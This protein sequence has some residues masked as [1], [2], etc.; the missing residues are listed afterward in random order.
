VKSRGFLKIAKGLLLGSAVSTI[1]L[2]HEVSDAAA[3]ATPNFPLPAITVDR[4]PVT[5]PARVRRRPEQV[6][7][8]PVQNPPAQDAQRSEDPRGPG[9]GIVA[10]QT[11]TGTKTNTSRMEIPQSIS[12]VTR[13]QMDL[14]KPRTL[15]EAT[16]YTLGIREN[17]GGNDTRTDLF[18]IRGFIAEATGLYLN[19]LQLPSPGLAIFRLEPFGLDRIEVLRGPSSVLYGGTNPGGL[20]NAISKRPVF[21]PFGHLEFG[22]NNYGNRYGAF[23]VGGSGTPGADGR[24]TVAYRLTGLGKAGGTQ[25]DYIQDDRWF[26]AP[27][28]TFKPNEDTKLTVL[29]QYQKDQSNNINFLPY[30]GTV[31]PAAYGRIQT[32]LFT[33][34]PSTDKITREQAMIGYEF[35]HRFNEVFT[36]RQNTRYSQVETQYFNAAGLGYVGTPTAVQASLRRGLLN[37][38]PSASVFNVDNQLQANF[39]TGWLSHTVLAGVDYKRLSYDDRS[40]QSLVTPFNLLNPNYGVLTPVLPFTTDTSNL[41]KQTGLYLQDQ[42]KFDRFTLV[43][44]GRQD[45]VDSDTLFNLTPALSRSGNDSAFSGRAGLIYTSALGLAP[46]V[47]YSRSFQPVIGVN[48]TTLTP[49]LPE[50]GEQYEVGVKRATCRPSSWHDARDRSPENALR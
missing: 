29:G 4:P 5:R 49:Y 37:S 22:V 41:Q 45:Y 25:T 42:I 33:G 34:E 11:E 48:P 50:T 1:G 28:I 36:V 10:N 39:A 18:R 9:N 21:T 14:Q 13:Q 43:V 23:D 40:V 44:S 46:Y 20:I 19:G 12:I 35:E 3:Q 38:Q 2:L 24:N 6:Q 15:L 31:V 30:V 32:S 47:A 16:R 26:I 8:A 7:R 27:A 17:S